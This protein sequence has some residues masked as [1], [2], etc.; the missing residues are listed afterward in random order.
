MQRHALVGTA[1]HHDHGRAACGH[2][3]RAALQQR[4]EPEER[5]AAFTKAVLAA[6][7][8]LAQLGQRHAAHDLDQG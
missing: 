2:A 4:V 7:V 8:G 1:H 6:G 3:A 5:Q